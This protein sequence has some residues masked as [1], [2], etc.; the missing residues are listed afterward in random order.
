VLR[1]LNSIAF[2]QNILRQDPTESGLLIWGHNI[3]I[4]P[5]GTRDEHL[6]VRRGAMGNEINVLALV[7]GEERYVFLY[8][9]EARAETLRTLGRFASNPELSFTWFD[10]AVLSQKVRKQL[11]ESSWEGRF[12]RPP[13]AALLGNYAWRLTPV[14]ASNLGGYQATH[15]CG[16]IRPTDETVPID[17]SA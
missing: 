4:R 7:K 12:C 8:T 14:L 10:A 9:D 3:N 11:P 2:L 13:P 1:A 15:T 5:L 16:A 17:Q 6:T